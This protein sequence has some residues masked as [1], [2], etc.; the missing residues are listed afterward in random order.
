[1]E[2]ERWEVEGGWDAGGLGV[3]FFLLFGCKCDKMVITVANRKG[4][5]DNEVEITI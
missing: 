4:Y 3:G 2:T 5:T 1:M